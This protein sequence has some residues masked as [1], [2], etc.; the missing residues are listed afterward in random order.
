VGDSSDRFARIDSN[1]LGQHLRTEAR[2][3]C[4][5]VGFAGHLIAAG[6]S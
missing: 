2:L 6:M 4:P 3:K 1:E 5:A